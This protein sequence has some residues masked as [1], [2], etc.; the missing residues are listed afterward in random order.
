[1]G[2]SWQ[3]G[4]K[5]TTM[6]SVAEKNILVRGQYPADFMIAESMN[7]GVEANARSFL[8]ISSQQVTCRHCLQ[9]LA[10]V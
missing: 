1:M 6:V 7:V 4:Q 2:M 3:H 9:L 10:G 5:W 8:L